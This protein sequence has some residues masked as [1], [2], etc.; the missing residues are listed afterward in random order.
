MLVFCEEETMSIFDGDQRASMK[1]EQSKHA[2]NLFL[3]ELA[4][5]ILVTVAIIAGLLAAGVFIMP[6]PIAFLHSR[7][8]EAIICV[9]ALLLAWQIVRA[10]GVE[11][12]RPS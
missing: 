8:G 11:P 1:E 5:G 10:Y 4:W 9:I 7:I 2:T 6:R 12:S 3:A